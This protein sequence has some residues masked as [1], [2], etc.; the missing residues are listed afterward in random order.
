MSRPPKVS[1]VMPSYQRGAKIAKALES[2]LRQTRPPDE[3]I[4]VNDGG[5]P[6]TTEW[7]TRHCPRVRVL[8]VEHG[9]AALAQPRRRGGFGRCSGPLRR[10]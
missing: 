2:V 5:F 7:V 4:V 3:I 6:P 8:D 9:G 1:L 10:R